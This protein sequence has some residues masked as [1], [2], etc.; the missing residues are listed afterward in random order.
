MLLE[1][2][3]SE[4]DSKITFSRQQASDFAKNVAGD[5]N[6]LHD[7]DAKRFCVP[8]DLLFSVVLAKCG[9]S[10]NM[11]FVFSGMVNDGVALN[12]PD[13]T[14]ATLDIVDDNGKKYLSLERS[15]DT[16][17]DQDLIRDLTRSCVR[18]SGQTFPH[19]LVPLMSEQQVMI[20]PNRPLVIYESM[21]INLDRLDFEN[22]QLEA[23]NPGFKFDGKRGNARL[24][25][26]IKAGGEIV[27]TGEKNMLISG[28]IAYDREKVQTMVDNYVTRKQR[29]AS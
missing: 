25:F 1:D 15:G 2:Y 8:G 21:A 13:T 17:Q 11:R 3:Y 29:L 9:L 19:V 26:C 27:G 18:F 24:K 28:L 7:T 16:T 14:S 10:Q 22:P 23:T 5:F 20:N 12:F 4:N 6:P